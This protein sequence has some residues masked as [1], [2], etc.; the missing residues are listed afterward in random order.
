MTR[1][2][3]LHE[4]LAQAVD[5]GDFDSVRRLVAA[6]A[7]PNHGDL[8]GDTPL[9][10]LARRGLGREIARL[11]LDAGANPDL[12]N[13]TG[14]TPRQLAARSRRSTLHEFFERLD[15]TVGG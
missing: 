6:G 5:D 8:A 12:P 7:D 4:A 14:D 15:G 11:L 3:N 10:L 1:E 2:N 9:H 13:R